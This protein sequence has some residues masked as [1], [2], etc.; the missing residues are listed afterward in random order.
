MT[1]IAEAHILH[2]REEKKADSKVPAVK[3]DFKA[4]FA[5]FSSALGR[6]ALSPAIQSLPL[7]ELIPT[8]LLTGES[9]PVTANPP[10]QA[11]EHCNSI[12]FHL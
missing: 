1:D 11:C 8:D 9:E 2:R 7:P 5:N 10:A 3:A 6:N 4:A 12:F